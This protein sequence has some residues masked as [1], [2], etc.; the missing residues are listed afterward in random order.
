M[1]LASRAG[2]LL[3]PSCKEAVGTAAADLVDVA[4]EV[5]RR[6]LVSGASSD[7]DDDDEKVGFDAPFVCISL[8]SSES[9][10]ESDSLDD[11]EE[12]EDGAGNGGD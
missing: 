8:S 5:V 4:T 9:E 10:S 2:I 11:D 6:F 12:V 1:P 7:D 3:V